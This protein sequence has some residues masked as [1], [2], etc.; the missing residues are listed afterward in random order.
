MVIKIACSN[1]ASPI[2]IVA[3]LRQGGACEQQ[4]EGIDITMD[5]AEERARADPG[6]HLQSHAG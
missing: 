3:L 4:G 2:I 1:G 6:R 5:Q